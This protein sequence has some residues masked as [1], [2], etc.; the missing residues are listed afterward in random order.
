MFRLLSK[1]VKMFSIPIYIGLVIFV[2]L[3]TNNFPF[4]FINIISNLFAFA[5]ISLGYILFNKL[6][7]NRHSHLPLFLYSIFIL[8]FYPENLDIGISMAIFINSILLFFLTDDRPRLRENSYFLIGNLLAL[9]FIFL[10]NTWALSLFVLIHIIAT[11]DKLLSNIAKMLFGII[12]ISLGYFCFMYSIGFKY[13]NPNYFPLISSEIQT[14]FSKLY[15]LIPIV[16]FCILGILDHFI[17]FNKKSP[18]NKF[19]YSFILAFLL[20]QCLILTF[21]MGENYEYLLLVTFPVC[22]IVSRFLRFLNKYWL[23][24]IGLWLIIISCLFSFKLNT[25]FLFN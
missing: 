7:L 3:T 15:F 13:F 18:Q 24:E 1:E 25:F 23:Q 17:N 12:I 20:T 5:G 8:S 16:I 19:K 22:V 14:D 11:S 21:Y 9:S 2:I 6:A 10:P 4:S